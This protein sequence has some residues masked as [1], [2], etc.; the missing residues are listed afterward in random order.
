MT[1]H[2]NQLTEAEA[3]LLACLSEECGEVVQV[4]GKILRHGY[5]SYNPNDP[6]E[7]PNLNLLEMELG[8]VLAIVELM[9]KEPQRNLAFNP[10]EMRAIQKSKRS[11]LKSIK[12]YLASSMETATTNGGGEVKGKR[13]LT[14]RYGFL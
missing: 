8:H 6:D 11:K 3:E 14:F 12:T 1:D 7:I 2:F 4:I 10:L 5:D 9:T 13:K